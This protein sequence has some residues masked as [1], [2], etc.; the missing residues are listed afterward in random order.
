MPSFAYP[1][2]ARGR[3]GDVDV[4][5]ELLVDE[6]GRV[7]DA[8]VREGGPAGLGFDEAALAASRK[9]SFQPGT[10]GDVPRKMWTEM[11]FAFSARR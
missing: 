1:A 9:V 7:I 11:I 10:R 2:A 8:V 6:R 5:L 3:A 4:R